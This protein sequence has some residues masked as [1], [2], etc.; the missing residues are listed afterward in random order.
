MPHRMV[1][2]VVVLLLILA[3]LGCGGSGYKVP[4]G[5]V[6]RG[7]LLKG[8]VA[9]TVPGSEVG[10]GWV[11]VQLIPA[12]EIGRSGDQGDVAVVS[13]ELTWAKPDG[14]FEFVG[15]GKGV[16]PGA[17]R[18]AVYQRAQGPDTDQLNG[19]FSKENTPITVEV[20]ET[21]G[22][23]HDLGTIDL[24]TVGT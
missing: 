10:V 21:I 22:G 18:L 9:L 19:V 11:E 24:E 14:S 15:A 8:G 13:A 20:P 23:S 4:Q 17:Y 16:K 2:A 7:K 12:T 6:V 1:R 3:C 5:V